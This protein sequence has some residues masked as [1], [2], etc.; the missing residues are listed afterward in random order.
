MKS[1]RDVHGMIGTLKR[2]GGAWPER[3]ARRVG[4]EPEKAYNATHGA[5]IYDVAV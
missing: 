5:A 3:A 1:V 4:R 2:G